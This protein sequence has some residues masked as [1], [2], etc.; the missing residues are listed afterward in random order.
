MIRTIADGKEEFAIPHFRSRTYITLTGEDPEDN[1]N[2]AFQE[3]HRV[4][5][6]I[7]AFTYHLILRSFEVL[8]YNSLFTCPLMFVKNCNR[9]YIV[10]M[11]RHFNLINV[12]INCTLLCGKE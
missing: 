7:R 3:V 5:I 1:L 4:I 6:S 8:C 11:W 2:A 10:S 12:I 9:S